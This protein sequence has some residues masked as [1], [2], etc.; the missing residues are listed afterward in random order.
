MQHLCVAAGAGVILGV[1][2]PGSG[3]FL[4]ALW[5]MLLVGRQLCRICL[6]PSDVSL[7][8]AACRILNNVRV[9]AVVSALLI[10]SLYGQI[11]LSFQLQHRLPASLDGTD[12]EL[13]LRIVA[14]EGDSS[15]ASGSS[16][17]P[18]QPN[19]YQKV[20]VDVVQVLSV[21]DL[22]E[23]QALPPLR[24]LVLGYYQGEP[25]LRVGEALQVRVR[26]RAIRAFANA[27]PFDYEAWMLRQ[28]VDA[29]GYIRAVIP[30]EGELKEPHPLVS[31]S[32]LLNLRQR[33]LT[34]LQ[35]IPSEA[36]RRWVSGL[37][38]GV[39]DAFLPRH[40]QL[41]RDTGTLHLLVV[42]GLHLGL[43]AG[44]C[45]VL[46]G[47]VVRLLAPAYEINARWRL[48][49]SGLLI[50]GMCLVYAV[51]AGAGIALQ[52][53][54]IMLLVVLI[55][56]GLRRRLAPVA[57]LS[58]AFLIVLLVN[59]LMFTAAGFGFSM[60]AVAALLLFLGGRRV[61]WRQGVWLPQWLV[62][63]ALL[64]LMLWWGQA[65]GLV[66][67]LCNAVAI[68]LLG[69]T[70]L[71]L[72]F[73]VLIWP[74]EWAIEW[75]ERLDR[76][77]WQGLEMA[78]DWPLP[79]VTALPDTLLITFI[80][81]LLLVYLGL[82]PWV[83]FLVMLAAL[84]VVFSPAS[85]H[86]PVAP[87][88]RLLDVGQGQSLVASVGG[89]ALVY[90]LGPAFG[91]DFS[92][93]EFM[94]LPSLRRLGNPQVTD[95]ILSHSD[96]DHAGGLE[97]WL[98]QSTHHVSGFS[99][100]AARIWLGQPPEAYRS[101]IRDTAVRWPTAAV[102]SCH[103]DDRWRNL[104]DDHTAVLPVRW[105]FL[106]TPE[107]L[108]ENDNDASCVMQLEWFG[109]RILVPGDI[110]RTAEQTL[111]D[112][113]GAELRSDVLVAS[114]HGSASSSSE[115]FLQQVD[116]QQV[117]I[118]AGFNNR[119]RHPS[120]VVITRLEHLGMDWLSTIDSGAISMDQRGRVTAVRDAWLP[121]WR[122]P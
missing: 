81:L 60:M 119:Y 106:R 75:I 112:R 50:A 118:S 110:S 52:R 88:L 14:R 20:T 30:A 71:P 22:P 57:A 15:P 35:Q 93:T 121:P 101:L 104:T 37:V 111:V 100:A 44:V 36:V 76:F 103:N 5:I 23:G 61:S 32:L 86:A 113:Y 3:C 107:R 64:P 2:V 48:W 85:W 74:A 97:V 99:G 62:F 70:L 41:A 49:G 12:V 79:V 34:Q 46:V 109:H 51:L 28:G 43:V 24:R 122:Q 102:R 73:L 96:L 38:F 17:K 98:Q 11:W 53:A 114:H 115:V 59:P 108:H 82:R 18:A 116:P 91:P 45:G 90:D 33:W 27:L 95:L 10:A 16:S 42:S 9:L 89:R 77:W 25:E 83:S 69:L 6:A 39:Q 13:V 67:L 19:I 26:L 55:V 87:Q 58:Y 72:A 56:L 80:L 21:A 63:C 4:L 92:A 54:W 117:W 31:E 47:L 66:H 105:R 120:P 84:A 94:L 1:L 8:G 78:L 65:V 40:W 7:A 29:R 68:P